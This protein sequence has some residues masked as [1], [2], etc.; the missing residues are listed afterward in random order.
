ML[1]FIVYAGQEI[2]AGKIVQYEPEP[3]GSARAL[4]LP[5]HRY[6]VVVHDNPGTKR[7]RKTVKQAAANAIFESPETLTFGDEVYSG[8]VAVSL[9]FYFTK[10]K[11]ARRVHHTVRPDLD[12]LCRAVLDGLKEGCVFHDDAQVCVLT[13]NKQYGSPPRCEIEVCAVQEGEVTGIVLCPVSK[14]N[15]SASALRTRDKQ[16]SAPAGASGQLAI[17]GI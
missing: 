12:K 11:T 10:P 15:N 5:K 7:W 9:S 4:I 3:Q 6:P 14:G 1:R 17:E 16:R 2:K 8:A 13:A